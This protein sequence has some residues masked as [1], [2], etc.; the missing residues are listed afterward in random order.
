MHQQ[1]GRPLAGDGVADFDAV[2]GQVF[3][4]RPLH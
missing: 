3:D 4:S 2:H 1:H